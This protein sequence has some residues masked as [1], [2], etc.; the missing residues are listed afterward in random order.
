[1]KKINQLKI[2]TLVSFYSFPKFLF[3][4]CFHFTFHICSYALWQNCHGVSSSFIL[5][6]YLWWYKRE[7]E[8]TENICDQKDE[9]NSTWN[10]PF[11]ESV[12]FFLFQFFFQYEFIFSCK[13]ASKCVDWECC[14]SIL[15]KCL[16]HFHC[17]VLI[18]L[19]LQVVMHWLVH[20]S[21]PF[22]IIRVVSLRVQQE[23]TI[24]VLTKSR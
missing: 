9:K 3:R 15:N 2:P 23:T 22:C 13:L 20:T 10:F 12:R 24:E 11:C 16:Y 4:F 6:L 17:S 21:V 19:A 5:L 8:G 1:M 18:F 7:Y 14:W